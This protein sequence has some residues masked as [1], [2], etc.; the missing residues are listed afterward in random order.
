MR[1]GLRWTEQAVNQLSAIAE[2]ISLSSPVYA[3]Q[4]VERMVLRLRQAQQFPESGRRVPESSRR[5]GQVGWMPRLSTAGSRRHHRP[6]A[7]IP[8]TPQ[9]ARSRAGASFARVRRTWQLS[10]RDIRQGVSRFLPTP[11]LRGWTS[12][13]SR[14]RTAASSKPSRPHWERPTTSRSGSATSMRR[15]RSSGHPARPTCSLTV[16][17]PTWRPIRAVL[18]THSIGSSSRRHSSRRAPPPRSRSSM[19]IRLMTTAMVSTTFP[20]RSYR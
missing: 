11:A 13:V 14:T 7:Y 6:Q 12:P 9:A 5:L 19:E 18:A 15:T 4:L 10:I 8:C 3:E 1:L 20:C 16:S 17:S 2:Y